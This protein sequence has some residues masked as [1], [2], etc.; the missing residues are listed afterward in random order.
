MNASARAR[1]LLA[2]SLASLGCD[3]IFG[4]PPPASAAHGIGYPCEATTDCRPPLVCG[5]ASHRCEARGDTP[6]GAA[7]TVT[8]ECAQNLYCG[9]EGGCARA[10]DGVEGALCGDTA[11]CVRGAVCFR[12]GPGLF[13]VCRTPR[14][15]ANVSG[16]AG[17]TDGGASATDG[18]QGATDGGAGNGMPG[19]IGA[20]CGDTLDC[21]AGLVCNPMLHSCQR[22]LAGEGG[23]FTP[24]TGVRCDD[25]ESETGPVKAYFELPQDDGTPAHDFFRL[26]F[27]NDARRDATTGRI[28]L[29]GFP[30]PGNGLIGF[31]LI[32]RY[33]RASERDLDGFGTNQVVYFRFSG[34]LD[35]STL[36]LGETLRLIDLTTGMP[37]TSLRYSASTSGNRYLCANS[38]T[39]DTGGGV[40]MEPG[41]TYAAFMTTGVRATNGR[42]VSPD[43]DFTAML[44]PTAPTGAT[45]ARAWAAY[46]PFRRYLAA[47]NIDR[48]TVLTA[49]VFTTQHTDTAVARLREAVRAMPVP[50]VSELVRCAAGV[51]SPCDD[52]LTGDAHVR[53]CVGAPDPAFDEYQATVEIPVFQRGARPYRTAG[54]G[55][56]ATDAMGRPMATGSERVCVTV[57][58]PRGVTAPAGGLPAVLYAHGTGGTYRSVITEGLAAGLSNVD[59]GGGMSARFITVGYEGVMHG[60]RRGDGVSDSPDVLF[61]NF[62]NPQA[63]RDNVLQGAADLFVLA[64]ALTEVRLPAAA[65]DPRRVMFVGHSQGSTVGVAAFAY[66]PSFAAAV[67][68]GAGGD[69]RESL[70]TKRRPVNIA[71][72]VPAVLQE[73]SV[74]AG[75]PA[76]NLLQA[77]IDRADAVNYGR[78][79]FLAR[80]MGVPARPVIQTYGLGDSY[81]TP[82]TMRTIASTIG[83]PAAAPIP[84]G[85]RAWPPGMGV[86]LP[87]THNLADATGMTATGALLESD[88]ASAYDGH[89]VMFRDPALNARVRVFLGT[90][91]TGTATVR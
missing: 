32:D 83:L 85:E 75:H 72:L 39:L 57:T 56:I 74:S 24:W 81:S 14:G 89:F 88:P 76:L 23:T 79:V 29:A 34:R 15:S 90:A 4:S 12:D 38:V 19:E 36:R 86:A 3:A 55:E 45:A 17:V 70:T 40:P 7:C 51:R 67:F 28:N 5:A 6:E 65:I 13:G 31:D 58:V 27:P 21:L 60:R 18:G 54:E 20:R 84:G 10:G 64:R 59:L 50:A 8:A 41:H 9:P 46:E 43:T 62:A 87:L 69:L 63:A 52:G 11:G 49:A 37:T 1:F 53:G 73:P 80:P 25:V 16:D 33:A 61:F 2:T 44:A 77:F 91:A 66:E 35:F 26:P 22:G 82:E 30:H 78:R 47:Q 68:S 48:A 42:P 71:A